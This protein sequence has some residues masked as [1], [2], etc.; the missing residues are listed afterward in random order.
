MVSGLASSIRSATESATFDLAGH[1][2][3]SIRAITK[4]AFSQPL[5][6]A[7]MIR[8][9]FVVGGGKLSRS[10]Y[11]D[12]A[13]Q[14]LT[15]TLKQ[16]DYV[17]DR[18]ASCIL[19]CAGCFKTQHDTGKNVFTVV[20]FPNV[21]GDNEGGGNQ[22][23]EEDE[24]P[25]IPTNSP[26]YKMAVCTQHTFKNLLS[27]YCV[28][29]T[30]KKTC[31]RTLE[32]LLQVE[33]AMES[34]MM[35][36]NPLESV[37]KSFYD[38]S[39]E[40]K[41]K[42]AH[43]QKEATKHI[44][45]G[46]ITKDEKMLLVEMNENR[47]ET[48]M[49]EKSSATTA[50]KLKKALARKKQL[51]SLK[52]DLLSDPPPLR[53]ESQINALRKKLLPLRTL[54][55]SAR[56]RLLTLAETRS[57]GQKEEM[58]DEISR[59]EDASC[60]WFE[61]EDVFEARLD[62]SRE[63]FESKFAKSKRTGGGKISMGSAGKGGGSNPVAKWI[64][65]GAKP[66]KSAWGAGAGKKKFKGKAGAVFTAMMLD[67]SSEE[68]D[69][70]DDEDEEEESVESLQVVRPAQKKKQQKQHPAATNVL[71]SKK[72]AALM[73]SAKKSNAK[74]GK[75][76]GKSDAS[77]NESTDEGKQPAESAGSAP[78]TSKK[79]KKKKKKGKNKKSKATQQDDDDDDVDDEEE[80]KAAPS[81]STDV[82]PRVDHSTSTMSQSLLEFWRSF[83]FPFIM[84]ILNLITLLMTSL[85]GGGKKKGGKKKRG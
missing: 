15:S 9:T 38:D 83:L 78:K 71:A 74:S 65:P 68:E 37:E 45:E 80:T 6:I 69:S 77:K 36:G 62:K 40:L 55:D 61:E 7:D 13:M 12:K 1:D 49:N 28:T 76:A 51:S 79:N 26:G 59:L 4:D 16:L 41:E 31:L 39:S 30:E 52:E 67:S 85:F 23:D 70:D 11:D 84:T 25:L 53:Y 47:I 35:N 64:L 63:R 73:A 60:G 29:Y 19:E 34:K 8:I 20:V 27:T 22:A 44:E 5:T 54:E 14:A 3:A 33:Q 72:V 82:T 42:Y 32:G 75:A 56:G 21:V 57:L 18:G 10:K 81:S 48:L 2:A 50:E 17:E 24:E 66:E 58:E 43:A 46:K